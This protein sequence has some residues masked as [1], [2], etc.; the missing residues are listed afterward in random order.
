M[1][2]TL[3]DD[4]HTLHIKM[5]TSAT[6]NCL[7]IVK[8]WNPDLGSSLSPQRCIMEPHSI[9]DQVMT[10]QELQMNISVGINLKATA[11]LS[12]CTVV[13]PQITMDQLRG[14]RFLLK[15]TKYSSLSRIVTQMDDM[16]EP[17]CQAGLVSLSNHFTGMWSSFFPKYN[18]SL[19]YTLLLSMSVQFVRRYHL[20]HWD[21]GLV[22]VPNNAT[23]YSHQDQSHQ[24][25]VR[26][27]EQQIL[28]MV[29]A[30]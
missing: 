4:K 21:Q 30:Q 26:W 7:T 28:D 11:C 19:Q 29:C 9:C 22:T 20:D 25:H 15:L 27:C 1:N 14:D 3:P 5:I 16:C 10:F 6:P 24:Y 23:V 2:T 8:C 18:G 12:V 17:A 13:P